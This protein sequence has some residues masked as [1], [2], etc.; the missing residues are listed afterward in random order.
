MREKE[1]R[2][3][4]LARL[5]QREAVSSQDEMVRLLRNLGLHATQS[6]VSRDVRELGL[7]RVS[8]QYV[9]AA[10]LEGARVERAELGFR[11]EL[12]ISVEPV[13]SNLIVVKTPPGTA[14]AV[15]I[16]LDRKHLPEIA[17]TLAGDDTIFVA[18]R[19]RSAQGRALALLCGARQVNSTPADDSAVGGDGRERRRVDGGQTT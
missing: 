1:R 17:G 14:N 6:S 10:R 15:A 3:A 18:V 5:V 16:E 13:G 19:S 12:I 11:S 9:P 4:A 2:Q 7:V 8:G